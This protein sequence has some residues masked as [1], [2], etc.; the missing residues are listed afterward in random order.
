MQ[1]CE[2]P[3]ST[4]DA[5]ELEVARLGAADSRSWWVRGRRSLVSEA[6]RDYLQTVPVS[7]AGDLGCG[8]GGMCEVVRGY[9]S[10][11]GIDRSP[12]SMELCRSK[13]YVGLALGLVEDLPLASASLDV[14][15]MTDVLE[16]IRYDE[17]AVRECAR[18]LRSGG[19]LI[20]TVPAAPLLFGE[21]DRALG[22]FRRYSRQQ[23][24]ALL[25]RNGFGIERITHFNTLLAPPIVAV[26][27][28]RGLL[29]DRVP[30]ADPLDLPGI[31]NALAYAVL[32]MERLILRVANLP[33]GLS[34][35]CV[36]RKVAQT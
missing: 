35:L 31:L 30:Q 16:H 14:A 9:C 3:L 6:L 12:L 18:V 8:A 17:Q 26:R 27:L 20:L 5:D 22:H 29:R 1:S 11:V 10:V 24:V 33:F 23:L 4:T 2:S 13:P 34:L 32:S 19:V 25:R 21:H 36:A 7:V 15:I 28:A